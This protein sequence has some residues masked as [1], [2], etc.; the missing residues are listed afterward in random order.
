[1][2]KVKAIYY[3]AELQPTPAYVKGVW[4]MLLLLLLQCQLLAQSPSQQYSDF[5]SYEF[6]ENKHQ[7]PSQV[8]YKVELNNN[9]I[10]L[11]KDGITFHFSNKE[12]HKFAHKR[13][14]LETEDT[15]FK[16]HAYKVIFNNCNPLATVEGDFA[17]PDYNNYFKGHRDTWAS[18][19]RKFKRITYYNIYPNIDL[20]V[21][22]KGDNF[23]YDF[24]IR[25][26]ATPDDIE[27]VYN[28]ADALTIS[29][30]RL[31]ITTS[32]NQIIEEAPY[33]YQKMDKEESPVTCHF[34]LIDSTVR[35]LLP[36]GYDK[37]KPLVIDPGLVFSTYSGSTSDNWGFT[38][39]YDSKG[40]VFAGGIAEYI[41]YPASP[42]AYQTT[43][44][45]PET[46]VFYQAPYWYQATSYWDLAI[47]KYDSTG[48]QRI[49][50]TYLGGNAAD[51]P[52]S[53]IANS[54]DELVIMGTT[55]SVNFPTT[56][57]AFDTTFN[58]GSRVF[59]DNV[60]LFQNGI[61]LFVSKL[62]VNGDSLLAST[63]IGGSQND[64]LNYRSYYDDYLYTGNDSLYYNYGDG[65]RGEV[66]IDSLDNIYIGSCT[67]SSD[68]PVTAGSAKTSSGGRQE[69]VVCK[70]STNLDTLVWST[71][72]GGNM[73][74][75]VNSIDIR[76]DQS[77]YATGGTNSTNFPIT[78]GAFRSSYLGGTA[79][80]FITHIAP[81]GNS[82]LH[83]TFYGSTRYDQAHFVRC[84]DDGDVF[85]YGQ[86]KALSSTLIYKA[87]YN[88][89]SSG[90][91]VARIEP[92][93]SAWKWSTVF[94]TGNG[95]PNI[96][97]TAFSVDVC[98]RVYLSGWG[99]IMIG[100][101]PGYKWGETFGTVG[102]DVTA[103]AYQKTTDGQD[104]YLMVMTDDG[105]MLQYASFFGEQHTT[106]YSGH[107]HVDGGTSRFDRLG[108]IYQSVCA[109]CEG[110]QDF[111]TTTGV[112]STSNNSSNCNNAVFKFN[113]NFTP[114]VANFEQP[115]LSCAPVTIN[116]INK[117]TGSNCTWD[118]GD[119][120][121]PVDATN[122]VHTYT[123]PGVYT[124]KLIADDTLAC[125][126]A[127]T[128][129]KK[130][131]IKDN[132]IG[133]IPDTTV[134]KGDTIA[135]GF[136]GFSDTVHTYVWSPVLHVLNPTSPTANVVTANST[137]YHIIADDGIC[138]DTVT[139]RI[140]TI[141]VSAGFAGPDQFQCYGKNITFTGSAPD[142]NF[143]FQWSQL[144]DLSDTI[145]SNPK[146][147]SI[148]L[149]ANG[150]KNYFLTIASKGCIKTDTV[151]MRISD[152]LIRV[153]TLKHINCYGE[154]N[155]SIYVHSDSGVPPYNYIW[156]NGNV[157]QHLTGLSDGSYHVTVSDVLGCVK[158]SSFTLTQ[159]TLLQHTL[160]AVLN[161]CVVPCNGEAI[162][163]AT[164]GTQP[165]IYT[166]NNGQTNASIENLCAG[167]YTVT[168]KDNHNCT[169]IDD[170]T[171]QDNIEIL[172]L[173][174]TA[175]RT[176]IYEGEV[177]HLSTTT[178]PE[179]SY[180]WTPTAPLFYEQ[181]PETDARPLIT[182]EF[183]VEMKDSKGCLWYDTIVVNVIDLICGE[184][185]IYIPNAFSPN[186]NGSNDVL[187]IRGIVIDKLYFAI[188]DRWGN[189]LFETSDQSIGWDGT[190][191]GEFCNPGVYVYYL[192]TEC[193]S[194]ETYKRKGNITL[195]R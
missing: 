143:T 99:R 45:T 173:N 131:R 136:L 56:K 4:G 15:I 138:V 183:Q 126:Y 66:G 88:N 185:N 73:D 8:L 76:P 86:T 149:S 172:N 177:T 117:S 113:V 33:A 166:W 35:F 2:L 141:P 23:K 124:V 77:V 151:R 55:G 104:F 187:K 132:F 43:P 109:S 178:Y 119:G 186:E 169:L 106:G 68:F 46:F 41:G 54:K 111:P 91:F 65:A 144:P 176:E 170:I 82:F 147:T 79:D 70:F 118:F 83:S 42:G 175:S 21:Y 31:I 167:T 47:I 32:I 125:N 67:F 156:S 189:K 36:A 20:Q 38:A 139:G 110:Y 179:A 51:L 22:S 102:M 190:Y 191:K 28:G 142:T 129:I 18:R 184:P 180:Q 34:S 153:D 116:F 81:S 150:N 30:R 49:Y 24:I 107:D 192:E 59:Y 57:N 127:D 87:L 40:N 95:E 135:Y 69:G 63:F 103:K 27:L 193:Y 90:Q 64:G 48:K 188:Y 157:T 164:G 78:A 130:F 61:D 163:T 9:A 60:L 58:A 122:P 115:P 50:A 123:Q 195:I 7:W 194:G 145:N 100:S 165:Y 19:V 39:S 6:I 1:M 94:G 181:L 98:N 89:P 152:P 53:I 17:S 140:N 12:H 105:N 101:V 174:T 120:T 114:I 137:T 133:S 44:S 25:P 16:Y 168:I 10:F 154:L 29:D 80:A 75:A 155:G 162:C 11:E 74:D 146:Q 37:N 85:I 97:P 161:H 134:C 71:Y 108:N 62:S 158:D 26:G 92:D 159:P 52:H 13:D 121:A 128:I 3:N 148:T 112:W 96:S 93:L 171:V 14:S 160:Q 72:L 5:G 182:T 84:N